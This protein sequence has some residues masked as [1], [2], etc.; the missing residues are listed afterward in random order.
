MNSSPEQ[1]RH[2]DPLGADSTF[3]PELPKLDAMGVA[4]F[5]SK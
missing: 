3:I 1:R 4:A 2:I 5:S